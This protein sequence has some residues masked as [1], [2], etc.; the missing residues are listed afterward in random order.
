M[1]FT[2][3]S[4]ENI[5]FSNKFPN[6][7]LDKHNAFPDCIRFKNKVYLSFRSAPY[8]QP[9]NKSIIIVVSSIDENKWSLEKIFKI[10]NFDVRDP[11]L[12]V[13][14]NTLHL[15]F[16]VVKPFKHRK[17]PVGIYHTK[18]LKDNRWTQ[19]KKIYKNEYLPSRVRVINDSLYMCVYKWSTKNPFN[20][21]SRIIVSADGIKWGENTPFGILVNE[22]T[23]ADFII[24]KSNKLLWVIRNDF[25][26]KKGAGSIICLIK[27]DGT[28]FKIKNDARKFDSPLLFKSNGQ[29][30]LIARSQISFKGKYNIFQPSFPKILKNIIN[31]SVYWFTKKSTAIWGFD[32]KKLLFSKQLDLP[33]CGDTGYCSIIIESEK[34]FVIYNYSSPLNLKKLSWRKGQNLPTS[35]YKYMIN[36]KSR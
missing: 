18:L 16:A 19:P 27:P 30:F 32:E 31:H 11:K 5:I 35:I 25:S 33:S 13:Y 21:E 28:L 7:L 14:K 23:E 6:N 4:I 34:S 17:H 20:S 36:L 2:L 26:K 29:I 9:N 8:H 24:T 22:G 3:L 12:V 1:E 10:P 15:Y